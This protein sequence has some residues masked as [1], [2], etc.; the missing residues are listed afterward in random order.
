MVLEKSF[1][2]K[3]KVANEYG[4]KYPIVE[5]VYKE[6]YEQLKNYQ[7]SYGLSSRIKYFNTS[8]EEEKIRNF[9]SLYLE[10]EDFLILQK[11]YAS[12]TKQDYREVILMERL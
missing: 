11:E 8:N 2:K 5:T 6:I 10:I 7:I 1:F 9:P 3:Q 4:P 12:K